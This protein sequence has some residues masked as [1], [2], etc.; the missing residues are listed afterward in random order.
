MEPTRTEPTRP[1]TEHQS[2]VRDCQSEGIQSGVTSR[3]NDGTQQTSKEV[4]SADARVSRQNGSIQIN[5]A[6]CLRVCKHDEESSANELDYTFILSGYAILSLLCFMFSPQ[7]NSKRQPRYFRN[8]LLK[9]IPGKDN[10]PWRRILTFGTDFDSIISTNFMNSI[11]TSTFLPLFNSARENLNYGSP[12]RNRAK[13][14]GII[15]QLESINLLG[16]VL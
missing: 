7:R 15:P 11:I 12:F 9:H 2:E 13:T 4:D 6:L 10:A 8:A 16:L 5:R 14:R 1:E 3:Q